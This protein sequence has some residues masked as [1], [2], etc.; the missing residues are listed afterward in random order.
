MNI[1]QVISNL[2]PAS[3]GPSKAVLELSEALVSSGHDVHLY[4]TDY[5]L[6]NPSEFL[7]GIKERG[8]FPELF[9]ARAGGR[10]C[11]APSLK[12]RL[13]QKAG[14][15]DVVHIHGLWTYPT[16][17]AARA[18]QRANIPYIVRPCG[19]LDHYCLSHHRLRKRVYYRLIERSVLEHASAIH[20][21][22]EEERERSLTNGFEAKTVVLPL[23]LRFHD[24]L[25]L[26]PIGSFRSRYPQWTGKKIILFLG[27]IS[28]KKG[29][30][31]LLESISILLREREDIH[32]VIAGPDEEGYGK[33]LKRLIR[34]RKIES[35][36]TFL[37]FVGGREKLA[38]LRDSDIFCLASHQENFGIAA[39]EACATGVPVVV[40]DQVNLCREIAS[41]QAGFVTGLRSFELVPALR[42]LL[43]DDDLRARMGANGRRLAEEKYQW[44]QVIG[45]WTALYQRIRLKQEAAARTPEVSLKV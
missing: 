3:G 20:F 33:T 11:F 35:D 43:S 30:D 25:S 24:Y 5:G 17:A 1:L 4:A 41:A 16:W 40:S 38:L 29:I 10:Y 32:C 9:P 45:G 12:K 27:R 44:D 42:R 39:L 23:G 26:P 28:F 13:G 14:D 19:M 21:T 34:R 6:S 31:L 36:V 7:K 15:F 8:F 22:S 18:C 2:S 37:G